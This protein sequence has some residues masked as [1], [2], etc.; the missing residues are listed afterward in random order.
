DKIA[1]D[2][3]LADAA[4]AQKLIDDKIAADKA[5]ADAAAAQ[6]LID[7]KLTADKV[8]ADA[9]AQ[10]KPVIPVT[11]NNLTPILSELIKGTPKQVEEVKH[12]IED[13]V[14][15]GTTTI[16]TMSTMQI[17][18]LPL[19]TRPVP[20]TEATKDTQNT[21]DTQPKNDGKNKKDSL[22]KDVVLVATSTDS[23]TTPPPRQ[24]K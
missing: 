11:Q 16:L 10:T 2:K 3:A 9:A 4:A 1:A 8:L 13:G 14:T 15:T 21:Q 6:K 20:V 24:C 23:K 7:D 5:L 18:P 17:T 19:Q 12:K 22:S